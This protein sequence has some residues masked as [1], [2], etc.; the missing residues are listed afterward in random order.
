MVEI[1]CGFNT[2]TGQSCCSC[3]EVTTLNKLESIGIFGI[4]ICIECQNKP[5]CICVS[6]NGK[7]I[8]ST[9]CLCKECIE[10]KLS[11]TINVFNSVKCI[12][13]KNLKKYIKIG[14][15]SELG[16]L[17]KRTFICSEC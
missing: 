2:K 5:K 17:D 8:A 9:E 11:N 10:I 15:P 4:K 13:C 16:E 14:P 6:C 7:K 1:L 12:K 3:N